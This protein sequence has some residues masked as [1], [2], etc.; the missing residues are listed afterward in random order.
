M[1]PLTRAFSLTSVAWAL[2]LFYPGYA[3][4]EP[5][6]DPPLLLTAPAEPTTTN[7]AEAAQAPAPP[8]DAEPEEAASRAEPK[9]PEHRTY[10]VAPGDTLSGIAAHHGIKAADIARANGMSRDASIR[11]GQEL[12]IPEPGER[13]SVGVRSYTVV[14]GDTL[15]K[16]ARQYG[17]TVEAIK[18]ANPRARGS[19]KIGQKFLIPPPN[20]AVTKPLAAPTPTVEE[21]TTRADAPEPA[22]P[23]EMQQLSVPGAP[24]ALYYEPT[25]PGRMSMRPVIM[26]LHGRGAEPD[27]YCRR[28]AS[29]AR[30]FGWVVCP[31]GPE[32]RGGGRR[33]WANNWLLANR[34]VFNTLNAL[35]NKYGRRVQL[36]GNTLIG[37]SEGAF[38]AMN[39]GVHDPRAFNRW[40][41]LGADSDYWGPIAL[42]DLSRNHD[43]I[44]RVYLI[45]GERDSVFEETEKVRRQLKDHGVAVRVS[46]PADM[47]HEVELES[48]AGMYKAA[49]HWLGG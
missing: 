36:Y 30:R 47:A 11:V 13:I 37:F 39:I 44:R 3:G 12:V 43:R 32:D 24:P 23:S 5:P 15:G 18:K 41:I 19:L 21:K 29:V 17:V 31:Q 7:T 48:K 38:V 26:Y 1:R 9:A 46:T 25:G 8:E 14:S 33:G 27:R 34:I 49:L 10:R 6:S 20:V 4:A 42:G 40:L 35:R 28:W 45:T 22:S 16:I 2:V